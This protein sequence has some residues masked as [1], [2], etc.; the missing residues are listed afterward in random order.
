MHE[1]S[2]AGDLVERLEEAARRERAARIVEIRLEL[3]A[4][5]GVDRDAFEF[6]FPEVARGTLAEGARLVV[7]EL[8]LKVR[9][10]ACGVE[11]EPRYPLFR[12]R[13][14]DSPEVDITAGREF[15]VLSMEVS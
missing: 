1:L 2:L 10:R 7:E 13:V 11:S 12:C 15:K 6:A 9:C 3:G 5:S 14:C 4:M 8:A